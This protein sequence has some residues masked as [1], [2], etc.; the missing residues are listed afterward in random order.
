MNDQLWTEAMNW[1]RN[2]EPS[3]SMFIRKVAHAK[4]LQDWNEGQ[5][6]SSSDTNHAI[7]AL[8]QQWLA[9]SQATPSLELITFLADE[10]YCCS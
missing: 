10:A 8:Y 4:L 3:I 5:G 1:Y 6:I 7:F 9:A 2:S